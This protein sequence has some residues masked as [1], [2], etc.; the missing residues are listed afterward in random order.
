MK[1]FKA[2][3]NKLQER[4]GYKNLTLADGVTTIQAESFESGESVNI[5]TVDGQRIPLNIG[6]FNL[7]N[8]KWL[9]V[10]EEGIINGYYSEEPK[11]TKQEGAIL[12]ALKNR[13]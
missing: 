8:G 2:I 9:V 7:S 4:K 11:Q 5:V 12:S 13:K 3:L 1:K 10:K 6:T